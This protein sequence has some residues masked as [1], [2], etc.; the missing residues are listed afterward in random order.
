[1]LFRSTGQLDRRCGNPRHVSVSTRSEFLHQHKFTVQI[2]LSQYGV[3]TELE[4]C[5]T[6][7]F[8]C[9]RAW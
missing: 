8:H 3:E 6:L 9:R 5:I 4:T 1:V 7:G 2:A